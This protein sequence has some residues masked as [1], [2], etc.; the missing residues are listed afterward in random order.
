MNKI[1]SPKIIALT[2]GILIIC[3]VF[4]FYAVAWQEPGSTPPTGNAPT[5]LN[6]SA[7]AQTKEGNLTINGVLKTLKDMIVSIVTIKGNGAVSTNLN[8]DK[9]DDYH[10]ADLMAAGGIPS[11]MIAMFATAC[12][13]GWTRFTALD[14]RFPYGAASYGATGGASTHTHGYKDDV[15]GTD[16]S[17]AVPL[18][19]PLPNAWRNYQSLFGLI[20]SQMTM[21]YSTAFRVWEQAKTTEAASPLPP[22]L[23]VIWCKKN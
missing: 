14:G 2:F 3:F 6:V 8:S 22:Y 11:G 1:I 7:T 12:P 5:P 23:G 16:G 18:Q 10:A 21:T 17:G 15:L 19:I 4:V 9:V 20:A 13:S